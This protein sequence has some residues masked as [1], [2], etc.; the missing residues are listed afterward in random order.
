MK[1]LVSTRVLSNMGKAALD[2]IA[3][4]TGQAMVGFVVDKVKGAK[5]TRFYVVD[6]IDPDPAMTIKEASTFQTGDDRQEDVFQWWIANWDSERSEDKPFNMKLSFMGDWHKQP[7]HMIQPSNGDLRGAL[8]WCDDETIPMNWMLVPI[9]TDGWK[10]EEE[11]IPRNALWIHQRHDGSRIRV[12]WWYINSQIRQFRPVR[13][14]AVDQRSVPQMAPLPFFIDNSEELVTQLELCSAAGY[15]VRVSLVKIANGVQM[16]VSVM[17]D[18]VLALTVVYPNTGLD[19][20]DCILFLG[21]WAGTCQST[22][23]GSNLFEKR[24]MNNL[25]EYLSDRHELYVK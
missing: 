8:E 23:D 5:T 13:A 11:E 19:T 10:E 12:D 25:L 2:N 24:K 16:A 7:G 15:E 6:T 3:V 22:I 1:V 18:E 9:V 17:L 21:D 14:V 20:D 4:E